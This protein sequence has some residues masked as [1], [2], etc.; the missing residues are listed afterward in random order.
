VTIQAQIL[1]LIGRLKSDFDSAVVLIT[2]DMGVVA[3]VADR[4]MVMYAG[5]VVERGVKHDLFYDAQ[6]PYTWGLLGSIPRLDRPKP[7]RLTDD[8]RHTA[9]APQPSAGVQ[10]RP[11]LPAAFRALLRGAA[12]RGPAAK[13]PPRRVLPRPRGEAGPP[14]DD[15]PPRAP[16]GVRVSQNGG[17]LV[18]PRA[19]RKV[20]PDQAGRRLQREVARV[21][22]VDDVSFDSPRRRDARDWSASRAAASRPSGRCIVACTS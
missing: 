21:H 17:P 4:V 6:H 22:A 9:V 2:H 3:D 10:L 16:D 1:E 5:R 11:A 14:R 8:P 15:D 19:C 20:L 13:R 7:E 12:A 18:T